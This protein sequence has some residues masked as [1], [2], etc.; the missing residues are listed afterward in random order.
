[1][2]AEEEEWEEDE[3]LW[4]DEQ[5]RWRAKRLQELGV[6]AAFCDA[7]AGAKDT[8]I[9]AGSQWLGGA[10]ILGISVGGPLLALFLQRVCARTQAFALANETAATLVYLNPGLGPLLLM[11][12]LQAFLI[13]LALLVDLPALA[14]RYN[15][16]SFPSRAATAMFN[17]SRPRRS[18]L[19]RAAS[20]VLRDSMRLAAATSQTPDEF[21]RA[22]AAHQTRKWA[23]CALLF[24]APGVV[25]TILEANSFWV[26]GPGGIVEHRMFPPFSSN[27]YALADATVLRTGCSDM[28]KRLIYEIQMATGEWFNLGHSLT[29]AV[30]GSKTDALEE[31]NAKL[32]PNIEHRRWSHLD[33]NPAHPDCLRYWAAR[34]DTD[35][36]RR[37]GVLLHLSPDEQKAATSE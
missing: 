33:R 19:G 6:P 26:G 3:R 12:G 20:W 36:P 17:S 21:V 4:R 27:R 7:I 22:T 18:P 24:S 25:V 5:R 30:R 34:F 37:L 2:S 11:F 16:A 28:E 31:I 9:A 32:N 10:I 29:S 8:M 1:M 15:V 23:I 35:G 14:G 13:L